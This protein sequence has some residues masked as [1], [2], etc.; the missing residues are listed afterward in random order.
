MPVLAAIHTGEFATVVL[1]ASLILEP[2]RGNGFYRSL[3]AQR[4][5]DAYRDG[6]RVA[7]VQAYAKTSAPKL[8]E[9][10]LVEV[11]AIWTWRW[12][13]EGTGIGAPIIS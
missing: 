13:P 2:Y 12:S 9:F 10:G 5:H 11:C 6:M 7:I 8:R 1:E 4:L 3:V